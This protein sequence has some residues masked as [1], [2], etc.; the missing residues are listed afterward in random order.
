[1]YTTLN[2]LSSGSLRETNLHDVGV[3]RVGLWKSAETRNSEVMAYL[4]SE[5][6][7]NE[8][9]YFDTYDEQQQALIGGDVDVV[10]SVSLSPV[11]NARI[12]AQFAPRPYYFASTK[13]N[14]AL[15]EKLDETIALIDQV[16]SNLQ[17]NLY[18]NYFRVVNEEFRLTEAQK[19]TF[20]QLGTLKVLCAENSAPFACRKDGAPAGMLVSILNDFG[21][22]VGVTIDYTFCDSRENAWQ[23]L[24][25]G[26]Y[27]AIVGIPLT[28]G[29]WPSWALSTALRPLRQPWPMPRTQ[30]AAA[31]TTAPR[32]SPWWRA[33]RS[34]L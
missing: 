32:R 31:G 17:D 23:K 24:R 7:G 27:D 25:E 18:N 10:S 4:E 16:D 5:K 2:A 1:M 14:T 28:S 6:L 3:L 29:V 15:I 33:C 19:Q 26:Q 34:R 13:G 22:Q 20:S 11:A 9:V 8:I 12:V 21:T 30:P